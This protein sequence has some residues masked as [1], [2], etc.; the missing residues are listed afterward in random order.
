M[1]GLPYRQE[2][3]QPRPESAMIHEEKI[4]SPDDMDR[5][6]RL[7]CQLCVD[8][9]IRITAYLCTGHLTYA[10][11]DGS[12]YNWSCCNCLPKQLPPM[13]FPN[14]RLCIAILFF[15]GRPEKVADQRE[16]NECCT[17]I[18]KHDILHS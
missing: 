13:I 6:D 5:E 18:A 7:G 17:E 4:M 12:R 2:P 15:L 1:K 3:E 8:S 10:Q 14:V 9:L 16:L 11:S